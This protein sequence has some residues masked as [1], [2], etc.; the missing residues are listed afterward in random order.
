M[1]P[2]LIRL[3]PPSGPDAA[4][5]LYM[6]SLFD[7]QSLRRRRLSEGRV[8]TTRYLLAIRRVAQYDGERSR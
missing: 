4:H 2:L 5:V 3:L 7:R 6:T 8:R 1:P